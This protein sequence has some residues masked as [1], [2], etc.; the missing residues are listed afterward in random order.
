MGW[1]AFQYWPGQ[2]LCTIC[3]LGNTNNILLFYTNN[4]KCQLG[5]QIIYCYFTQI[6]QN[7]SLAIQIIYYSNNPKYFCLSSLEVINSFNIK[8]NKFNKFI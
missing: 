8:F 7:V 4:P 1:E 5:K 3:Q 6:I 2:H